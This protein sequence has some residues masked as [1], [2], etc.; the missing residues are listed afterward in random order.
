LSACPFQ[1]DLPERLGSKDNVK[2][3]VKFHSEGSTDGNRFPHFLGMRCSFF[4]NRI[5]DDRQEQVA[6]SE[7]RPF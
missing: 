4:G 7:A 2:L 6:Y 1:L 5:A 3:L